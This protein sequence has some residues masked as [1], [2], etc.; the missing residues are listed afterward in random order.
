MPRSSKEEVKTTY[1]VLSE[2]EETGVLDDAKKKGVV[3]TSA[4]NKCA[5][6]VYLKYRE[7]AKNKTQAV[8]DASIEVDLSE[9]YMWDIIKNMET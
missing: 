7:K 9:R 6:E 5:Y 4:F 8:K 1:S 2:M 3:P